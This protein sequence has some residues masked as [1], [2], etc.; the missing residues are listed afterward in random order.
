M[1]ARTAIFAAA[2]LSACLLSACASDTPPLE[3]GLPPLTEPDIEART[4]ERARAGRR[5]GFPDLSAIPARAETAPTAEALRTDRLTL[6]EEAAALRALRN[7]AA[8]GVDTSGLRRE[9]AALRA[10]VARDR[11][12]QA[13]QEPLTVPGRE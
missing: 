6:E 5:R 3:T 11:A 8:G 4:E 13:A 2:L 12:Q 10:A 7:A 9:G 1:P